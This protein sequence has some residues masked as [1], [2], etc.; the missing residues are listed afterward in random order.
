MNW[1]AIRREAWRGVASGAAR[2]VLLGIVAAAVILVAQLVDLAVVRADDLRAEG[3]RMAGADVLV[4]QAQGGIDAGRCAALA[5]VPGVDGAGAIRAAA[6]RFAAA[7]PAS[8]IPAFEVTPGFPSVLA[9]PADDAALSG[10]GV[11]LSAEAAT[12]LDVAAGDALP[13]IDGEARVADVYEYPSDGRMLGLGYAMLLPTLEEGPFDACWMRAWPVTDAHQV[14]LQTSA[15]GATE[16]APELRQLNARLGATLDAAA[17]FDE[18]PS[19]WL[20]LAAALVLAAIGAGS[21]LLRRL[22]L[23]SAR[24]LGVTRAATTAIALLEAALWLVPGILAALLAGATAAAS[25][26][27]EDVGAGLWLATLAPL[28]GV[29]GALV[30]TGVAAALIDERA[31]YRAFRQR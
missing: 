17:A 22:E 12:M 27:A 29:L 31:V 5:T 24:H 7:A 14:L 4:L 21:V 23:A 8:S 20:P 25:L 2:T 26:G 16:A 6:P 11:L 13:L 3:F 1:R 19:R 30:G 28:G 9:P 15:T 18:R 10:A